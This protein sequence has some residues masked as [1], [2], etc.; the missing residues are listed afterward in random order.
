MGDYGIIGKYRI[1]PYLS[2]KGVFLVPAGE[3]KLAKNRHTKGYLSNLAY[4]TEI[5]TRNRG[6][7]EAL[8]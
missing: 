7:S 3:M 5:L 8:T 4:S 1:P 2:Y 6:C